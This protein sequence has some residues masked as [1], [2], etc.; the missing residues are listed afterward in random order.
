MMADMRARRFL[1]G[2]LV[3]A[4]ASGCTRGIE[5]ASEVLESPT[6]TATVSPTPTAASP[7]RAGKPPILV[8][9]PLD[10]DEV[11]SP[12]LVRGTAVLEDGRLFVQIL[13]AHGSEL[14]A[15]S[16]T[17]SCF[18]DC[19]GRFRTNLAFFTPERQG[20]TVV[21]SGTAGSDPASGVSVQ[22]PV[23]LVP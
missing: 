20:G 12:L 17:T 19:R 23:T 13:D 6:S 2:I 9:T 11:V 15:I 5:E 1:A 18:P 4:L 8:R 22:V 3:V 7:S 21:V 16:V 14:A 10:G